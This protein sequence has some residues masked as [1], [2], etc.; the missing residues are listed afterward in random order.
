MGS[1]LDAWEKYFKFGG[2]ARRREFWLFSLINGVLM[3]LLPVVLR[4]LFSDPGQGAT[5]TLILSVLLSLVVFIPSLAVFSR[6]LHDTGRSGWWFLLS[7][8]PFGNLLLLVWLCQD[9]QSGGNQYGP[10]PKDEALGQT[11][12]AQ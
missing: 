1:Y 7:F 11:L 10:N 9:S 3:Y 12:F 8:V 5:F 2:R 6:R 4:F